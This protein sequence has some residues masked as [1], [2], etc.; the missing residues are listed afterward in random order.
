MKQTS[1]ATMTLVALIL[2]GCRALSL[3][4]AQTPASQPSAATQPDFSIAPA[5][6]AK[7]IQYADE[8]GSQAL[9]IM[10]NGNLIHEHYANGGNA[11]RPHALASG[12]KS[13]LGTAYAAAVQD[14]LVKFDDL[15]CETLTEWKSD[16][17]KSRI[18]IRQLISLSSGLQAG[19]NLKTATWADSVAAPALHDPGE[20]FA[21]GPN[22]LQ[23]AA[24]LLQRKLK[25][26]KGET[27]DQY[28]NRRILQPLNIRV[29][30]LRCP[31]GNVQVAGGALMTAR[32][33]ATFGEFIRQE[34]S[35]NGKS[36]IDPAILHELF[37]PQK[38]NPG[39]GLTWWLKADV[40][41]LKNFKSDAMANEA[42]FIYQPNGILADLVMAAG[43]GKQRL[44]IIP[45]LG[46]TV[47]RFG[48]VFG[49][50]SYEDAKMMRI[51][52]DVK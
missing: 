11:R 42:A 39:Y 47:V 52:L 7:A 8:S 9:L 33:W 36:L 15:A 46:L 35:I 2:L 40:P 51:I 45:S 43:L 22:Q 32:D 27:Y 5:N 37:I 12:S 17:R 26:A 24:E 31:D 38:T 10:I 14:G 20:K 29:T 44:Y 1:I 34:G 21:Y 23:A 48:P 6:L 28:L 19:E 41:A 30:W 16:P 13:F 4:A 3:L 18:T 25:A 49:E 50:Q